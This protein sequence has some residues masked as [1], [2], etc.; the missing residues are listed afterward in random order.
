MGGPHKNIQTHVQESL[1][2]SL[3]IRQ[4]SKDHKHITPG[5]GHPESG[6]AYIDRAS[7]ISKGHL[8]DG[9]VPLLSVT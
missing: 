6:L 7:H 1:V 9:Q 8:N 2:V 5:N 4:W 3:G